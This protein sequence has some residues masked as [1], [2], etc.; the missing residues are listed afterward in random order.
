MA[1]RN[2]AEM[3]LAQAKRYADRVLYRFGR[4]GQWESYTWNDALRRVRQI[5]LGLLSLEVRKGDRVALFSANRVEWSLIDWANIC[6]G[7]LSVPIYASSSSAQ[8]S[9]IIGHS[10]CTVLFV[11]SSERLAKLDLKNPSFGQLRKIVVIDPGSEFPSVAHEGQVITLEALEAMGRQYGGMHGD[12]FERAIE[13][14]EPED[15]L[16][17]IYTS[18]TTGDPKGVLT[19]HHHYL[20]MID[21]VD[22]ALFSSDRDVI[23]QFLPL[24]HS[25]GRLEHFMVVAKGFTCG[26]AR[27][28]E[29]IAK[30]L[31]VIRPTLLFSVP[32]IYENAYSRIRSRAV[33]S[34]HLQ[35]FFFRLGFAIGE[36]YSLYQREGRSSP[37]SLRLAHRLAS[38]LVFSKIQAGFGGRLRLAVSGGAPLAAEIAQFFHAL[39]ILVLEG[40]GLTESATVSHVNRVQRYRFGTVGLSLNGVECRIAADGEILL[41]GPN[42]FKGYYRDT[43]GTEE[44][45]DSQGW[46]H[47]GDIGEIDGEG[48]LRITDRKKDLIV[49]SG[50]KKVAPQIIEN[51]LKGDPLISQAMVIGDRQRHLMALIALDQERLREWAGEEGLDFRSGEEIAN[52]PRVQ[53]LVKE[54]I[55]QKNKTLAPYEAVRSFRILPQEFSLERG[56]L[57]PTLKVRRQI[58]MERYRD[59]IEDMVHKAGPDL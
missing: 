51:L 29:T 15:D 8:V 1:Y 53:A 34:G 2:L 5:A 9:F 50:G 32:R 24:A 47:T 54:R 18:G 48:F 46:F 36:R 23:L 42:I 44:A 7:A 49:T 10:G 39:G 52:H 16:T 6:V 57:T 55:R 12:S 56:E 38:R 30:D 40:Y 3:F 41:R 43:K 45:I 21:A 58:V 59:I 27:S 19:A 31:L 11:E 26:F 14:V 20:F 17:I 25:F 33:A 4:D 28:M 37:L 13:S 35:K 22:E